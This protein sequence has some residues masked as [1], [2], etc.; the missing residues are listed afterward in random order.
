MPTKRDPFRT[1]QAA[2]EMLLLIPTRGS[3]S[4]QELVTKLAAAGLPRTDRAV[5]RWMRALYDSNLHDIEREVDGKTYR[6]R[7]KENARRLSIGSLN[8]Q[9]CL[10]LTLAEQPC[11]AA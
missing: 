5:Q 8:A 2:V 7:R 6:Y 9:E 10:L 1:M 11:A 4:T 3:I